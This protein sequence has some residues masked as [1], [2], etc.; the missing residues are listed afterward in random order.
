[1]ASAFR[2]SSQPPTASTSWGSLPTASAPTTTAGRILLSPWTIAALAICGLL[3]VVQGRVAPP[4][5]ASA[6]AQPAAEDRG[7]LV[8]EYQDILRQDAGT[9]SAS[10][11]GSVADVVG[12]LALVVAGIGGLGLVVRRVSAVPAPSAAGVPSLRR[13]ESLALSP[14]A[15]VHLV[16][17]GTRILVLGVTA[18]QVTLLTEL[19]MADLL[20]APDV[21]ETTITPPA[22][23]VPTYADIA[24]QIRG[25]VTAGAHPG[26]SQVEAPSDRRFGV[27]VLVMTRTVVL[28]VVQRLTRSRRSS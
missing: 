15:T 14:Q 28:K 25:A 18:Q 10:S 12:K 22:V 20:D 24:Q 4:P 6:P 16:E 3:L 23:A 5:A 2:R 11:L 9:P 27:F 17:V 26:E 21:A 7:Y 19:E 8:R 13:R 1:M